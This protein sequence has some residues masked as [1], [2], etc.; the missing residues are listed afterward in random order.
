MNTHNTNTAGFFITGTDTGVGKTLVSAALIRLF[1][2][3]GIRVAGMKPVASGAYRDGDAWRNED[4]EMLRAQANVDLPA[5]IINPYQLKEATAPHIAA[6]AEGIPI[7]LAHI[8]RC[9]REIRRAADMVIVEGAGGF[10][11]P[12]NDNANSDD[13]AARLGLPVI[14]VVG[15]RLGCINHALLTQR[16]IAGRGLRLAG[17]VANVIDPQEPRSGAMVA[18][19]RQRIDTPM[20]GRLPWRDGMDAAMAA[21]LLDP[22]ILAQ[23]ALADDAA[24]I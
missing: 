20:L 22:A 3:R 1:A 13:L 14:L 16:A 21:G 6:Q 23:A 2:Q 5:A 15:I 9:Y 24:V 10:V 11:V 12:L 7:E 8:E 19:L 4:V 18:S 17:W